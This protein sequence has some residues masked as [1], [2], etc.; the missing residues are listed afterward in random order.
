[1]LYH[2][3]TR[4]IPSAT[5]GRTRFTRSSSAILALNLRIETGPRIGLFWI[6][7]SASRNMLSKTMRP[8]ART[9]A[10]HFRNSCPYA[11]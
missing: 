5:G 7:D 9:D 11:P 2:R 6:C 1:M 10:M 4:V 3:R 8:P